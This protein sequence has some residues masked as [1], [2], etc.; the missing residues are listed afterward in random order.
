MIELS[1]QESSRVS[2]EDV[3]KDFPRVARIADR[4]GAAI[5]M[6]DNVPRYVL[7]PYQDDAPDH[8][9]EDEELQAVSARIIDRNRRAYEVLAG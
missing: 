6:R 4:S 1:D 2:L 8:L 7:M 3:C 9:A 5:I